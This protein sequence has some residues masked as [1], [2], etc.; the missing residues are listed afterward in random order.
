LFLGIVIILIIVLTGALSYYQ[1][2]KSEAIMESIK[3]LSKVKVLVIREPLPG[4]DKHEQNINS[5]D[6]V[7]GDVIPVKTGQKIPADLRVIKYNDFKLDNSS[8][9][10]IYF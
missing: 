2:N 6:V 3:Q 8:L 7:I 9:T 5:A 4:S 10:V 1:N